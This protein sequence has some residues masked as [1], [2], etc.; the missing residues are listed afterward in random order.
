MIRAALFV[1]CVF[2]GV[3]FMAT[4]LLVHLRFGE[5]LGFL[6]IAL[7]IVTGLMIIVGS[8]RAP[9]QSKQ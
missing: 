6:R 8:A 1:I 2:V 7:P 3:L 5:D 9:L 4:P